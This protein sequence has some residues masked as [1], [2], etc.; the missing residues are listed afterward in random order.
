VRIPTLTVFHHEDVIEG[1]L[2]AENGGLET[3][4]A[5]GKDAV[6]FGDI[7]GIGFNI[8]YLKKPRWFFHFPPMF[9]HEILHFLFPQR[10]IVNLVH[11][12]YY[13]SKRL[14]L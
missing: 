6:A 12:I 14:I 8:D 13:K 2:Y 4:K 10:T 3:W 1:A 9:L 5:K 11:K 7:Y